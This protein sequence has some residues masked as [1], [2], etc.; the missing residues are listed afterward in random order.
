MQFGLGPLEAVFGPG[1]VQLKT[2]GS[3]DLDFGFSIS[4]RDNPA[5]SERNR[6]NGS[7][8]F[9]NFDTVDHDYLQNDVIKLLRGES[10]DVSDVL[11]CAPL[12]FPFI[13]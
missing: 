2:Q 7:F 13:D 11:C 1:G 4:K 6:R 8:D 12:F 9:D 5:I 3:V 10:G